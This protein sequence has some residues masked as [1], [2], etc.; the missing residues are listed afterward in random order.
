MI[1]YG[2]RLTYEPGES[3]RLG[4]RLTGPIDPRTTFAG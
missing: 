4:L 3:E 2:M 1:V